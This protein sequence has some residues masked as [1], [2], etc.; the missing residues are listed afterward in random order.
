[1]KKLESKD[2]QGLAESD[3]GLLFNYFSAM[4][5]V[6][7]R[8]K[9]ALASALIGCCLIGMAYYLDVILAEV[10]NT[11]EWTQTA[12]WLAKIT[13]AI[14]F[15]IV[16]FGNLWMVR[17]AQREARDLGKELAKRGLDASG[18]SVEQ[19][20]EHVAMPMFR[21]AGLRIKE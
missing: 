16:V 20:F 18:L 6:T 1:M 7:H 9:Q 15:P 2:L 14:V 10:P 8:R 19:I 12:Q 4:S 13:P 11:P 17:R 5:G 3:Q 21:R